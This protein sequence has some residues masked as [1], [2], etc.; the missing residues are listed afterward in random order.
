M[1]YPDGDIGWH[2]QLCSTKGNPV[3]LQWYLRQRLLREDR[4]SVL[5]PLGNEYALDGYLRWEQLRLDYIRQ[6]KG[7]QQTLL[8]KRAAKKAVEAG[9]A[10]AAAKSATVCMPAEYTGSWKRQRRLVEDAHALAARLG[11]PTFFITMTC[12]PNWREIRDEM[13]D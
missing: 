8:S 9:D 11:K 1:F 10:S 4:F 6:D 13:R 3:H 5:G 2:K 12:N 7:L